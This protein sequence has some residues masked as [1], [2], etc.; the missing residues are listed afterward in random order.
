M[1]AIDLVKLGIIRDKIAKEVAELVKEVSAIL[2][3]IHTND[4]SINTNADDSV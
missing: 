4:K 1:N 3:V 2:K